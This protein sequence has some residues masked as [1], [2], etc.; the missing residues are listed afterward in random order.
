M[1]MNWP[2]ASGQSEGFDC[3]HADMLIYSMVGV[4]FIHE[5]EVSWPDLTEKNWMERYDNH[6]EPTLLGVAA[7]LP[8]LSF[9]L[10]S[11][12][13]YIPVLCTL[14]DKG[15]TGR[16]I[17]WSN[18][19]IFM[20]YVALAVSGY[21]KY[22]TEVQPNIMDNLGDRSMLPQKWMVMMV[23][24]AKVVTRTMWGLSVARPPGKTLETRMV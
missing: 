13:A 16:L 12:W 15:S 19:W 6:P 17:I 2:C 9:S 4:V 21:W 5:S 18:F 7:S 8:L 10:N 24:G 20:N 22:G 3:V 14:S 23:W 11:S 1:T